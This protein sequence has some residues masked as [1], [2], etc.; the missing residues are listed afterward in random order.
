MKPGVYI[1]QIGPSL[2]IKIGY[3]TKPL[4]RLSSL[5]NYNKAD[6]TFL[7]HIPGKPELEDEIHLKFLPWKVGNENFMPNPA[8]DALIK[9]YALK[10]PLVKKYGSRKPS[11]HARK[12]PSAIMT[13]E[14]VRL[15]G[16]YLNGRNG[17]PRM[18]GPQI[19][20]KLGV[21]T[22]S[23]YGYWQQVGKGKFARKR[24]GK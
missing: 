1:A 20:K 8:L 22:A 14:R 9:Q 3:S 10:P 13:P 2:S 4:T 18:T 21:S 24:K 7:A 12:R 15:V 19:A 11:D 17:K 6:C 16:D 5:S 23:I